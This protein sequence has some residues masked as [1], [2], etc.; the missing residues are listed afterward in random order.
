[1]PLDGLAE[2]FGEAH[3]GL[4]VEQP[5][6][7]RVVGNPVTHVLVLAGQ[8]LVRDEVGAQ[9]LRGQPELDLDA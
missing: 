1:M 4:E 8:R 3:P 6:G 2:P 5:F 7:L 9:R